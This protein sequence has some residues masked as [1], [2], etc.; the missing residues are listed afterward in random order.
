MS[1]TA[2]VVLRDGEVG[3]AELD[4]RRTVVGGNGIDP[5]PRCLAVRKRHGQRLARLV[6]PQRAGAVDGGD[7]DA[8]HLRAD[9][10]GARSDRQRRVGDRMIEIDLQ[11]LADRRL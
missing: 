4:A 9:G 10:G 6:E 1:E 7:L 11:P 3:D 2:R 5:H 8:A